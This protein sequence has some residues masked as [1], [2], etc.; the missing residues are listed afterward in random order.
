M[1][2][3]HPWDF[4]KLTT[5]KLSEIL[6]IS[7]QSAWRKLTGKSPLKVWEAEKLAQTYDMTINEVVRIFNYIRDDN[8]EDY[9]NVRN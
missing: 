1:T 2:Q 7:R 3:L 6:D 8:K 9:N 4:N 5:T